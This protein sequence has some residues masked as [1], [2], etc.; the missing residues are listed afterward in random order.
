MRFTN[1]D[2]ILQSIVPHLQRRYGCHTV[3][4]Y[5][6]RARNAATATSDY[7][8]IGI[9]KIG[10]K[11][12]IAKKEKG[13]YWDVFVY[14][15]KDLKKLGPEHL[16]WRDAKILFEKDRYGRDLIGRIQKL[17]QKPFKPDP[18][19]EITVSKVWSQKQLER[20]KVGDVHGYY[21]RI[22]LQ[23]AA[24]E[25]YFQIRRKRFL[26]PK[27]ALQWLETNDPLS[28]RL[29]AEMFKNPTNSKTLQRLVKRVYQV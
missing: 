14:P 7:D 27:A 15:E 9:R 19:Y 20:L 28:F 22:E 21:R 6:S 3:I 18:S 17:V 24:V 5:G 8:V 2:P 4:L 25:H 12:R 23:V 10:P 1:T 13:Y 16:G 26:G 11:T 29:F